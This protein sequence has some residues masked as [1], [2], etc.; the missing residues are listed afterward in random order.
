[1]YSLKQALIDTGFNESEA[2]ELET[3]DWF[4]KSNGNKTAQEITDRIHSISIV[5]NTTYPKIRKA[6]LTFPQFAG[7]DHQRV[8]KGIKEAYRCTDEQ[9][10]KAILTFPQFAGYNHQRVIKQLSRLGRIVGLANDETKERILN[11]P[12][13]A[14]YSAKRYIAALDIGRHLHSEGIQNDGEMLR[15]WNNGSR[16]NDC[17]HQV[18]KWQRRNLHQTGYIS[19]YSAWST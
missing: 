18:V 6:I 11:R 5:Y 16:R 1:M 4:A 7:L 15:R 19:Q 13:F 10:S 2:A 12:V 17:W 14:S 9:A 8:I 3:D